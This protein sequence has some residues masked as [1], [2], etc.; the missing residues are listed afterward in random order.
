MTEHTLRPENPIKKLFG[1]N[2]W[3][4]SDQSWLIKQLNNISKDIYSFF[5]PTLCLQDKDNCQ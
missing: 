5:S 4:S 3:M 1:S 2:K